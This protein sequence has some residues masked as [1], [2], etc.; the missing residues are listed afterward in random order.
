MN[1]LYNYRSQIRLK[2][3]NTWLKTHRDSLGVEFSCFLFELYRIVNRKQNG[4][5]LR[6]ISLWIN[7]GDL[8]HPS[9]TAIIYGSLK[10]LVTYLSQL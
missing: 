7:P 5:V 9:T 3:E 10:L 1:K 8:S 4:N 2:F 6:A